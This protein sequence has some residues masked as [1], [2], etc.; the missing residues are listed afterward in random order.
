M[1]LFQTAS[2]KPAVQYRLAPSPV[3]LSGMP[4]VV[5][6]RCSPYKKRVKPANGFPFLWKVFNVGSC[7]GIGLDFPQG[8][9]SQGFQE[10]KSIQNI[11]NKK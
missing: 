7:I 4:G 11:Q 1:Q 8:S 6:L 2:A 10:V 3:C 5:H 9:Q